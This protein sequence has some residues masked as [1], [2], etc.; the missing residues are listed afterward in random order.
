MKSYLFNGVLLFILFV[1]NYFIYD[2]NFYFLLIYICLVIYHIYI[3]LSFIKNNSLQYSELKNFVLFSIL[4]FLLSYFIICDPNP[5]TCIFF[6]YI[7]YPNC[8]KAVLII[9][10]H[11]YML[12][13]YFMNIYKSKLNLNGH[14]SINF[15]FKANSFFL[16]EFF[17][18]L[19]KSNH[20]KLIIVG[21]IV[22]ILIDIYVFLNKTYLWVNFNK[23][24]KTL[25]ILTSRD[26]KFYIT[27]NIFNMEKI[28]ERF[29]HQMKLL[30]NYLGQDNVIISFVENGDSTDNTRQYLKD[31]QNYLNEKNILNKFILENV[32][33]DPRKEYFEELKYTRLRIEYYTKLR[34]KCLDYLY[35]LPNIDFNNIMILFFNDVIFNYED[36]IKLLSTNNEVY[37]MVCAMDMSFLF[38]DR[39]VSIDLN[40]EGMMKYFPF[41]INKEGQDL[42]INHRPIRVFSCWNGVIAFKAL[43]L[44]DK[45]VQFR[46]KKSNTLPNSI[47]KNPA[48]TYFESECTYF[49]VDYFNLG[50]TKKFINPDVRVSYDSKYF[51]KSIYFIPSFKHIANYFWSYFVSLLRTRNKQMSNYVD[52]TIKLKPMLNNWYLENIIHNGY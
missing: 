34:N 47:L 7:F 21:L 22:F 20:Y 4:I 32:I 46:Y 38:Y 52:T 15:L 41:F 8:I 50:F 40:G 29:I 3:S 1:S 36:I 26:T 2:Y 25:P 27:S 14:H 5:F 12:N 23:K 43:P 9:I 31:F 33:S 35:E 39:W 45:I 42:V 19:K 16:S 24:E 37:D 51:F 13:R 17:N 44:K 10:I 48:K 18:D 28:I 6:Y 49:N 11:T 30:I